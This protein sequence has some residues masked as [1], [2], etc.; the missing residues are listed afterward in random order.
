MAIAPSKLG[1]L[2][3]ADLAEDGASDERLL[4]RLRDLGLVRPDASDAEV[5]STFQ[6]ARDEHAA[7]GYSPFNSPHERVRVFLKP[8]LSDKGTQWAQPFESLSLPNE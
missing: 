8:Y 3:Y 7:N 2:V 6:A 4:S 5:L 1:H